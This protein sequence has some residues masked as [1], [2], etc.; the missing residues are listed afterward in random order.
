L[1]IITSGLVQIEERKINICKVINHIMK[2]KHRISVIIPAINEEESIGKVVEEVPNWVDEIIVVDNGSVDRTPKVAQSAGAKVLSEK[3]KGYGTACLTGIANLDNPEIVVFLDG[4]YSDYPEEMHLVVDPI[5][6]S[7]ADMV[8]GS[9]VLGNSEKGALTPQARFGNW[10]SCKLIYLFWKVRYTDL[11]PFRAIR[12]STLKKL[13]MHDPNFGWTVE[14]QIKAAQKKVKSIEVPVSYR[15]RIGKSKVS[16]TVRG[17]IL[18]GTKI[19]AI[20][21][22]SAIGIKGEK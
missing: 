20:I 15:R 11:G 9:R 4:D 3:Q 7:E 16:G 22:L 17:V 6:N 5:I 21:F 19:L 12:F 1:D 14:M 8:I 18:A 13:N 2:S 10:L